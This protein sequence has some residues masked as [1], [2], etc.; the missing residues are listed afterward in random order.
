MRT[1]E[2]P[3]PTTRGAL[4]QTLLA[5]GYTPSY[6]KNEFGF[7]FVEYSH[8]ESGACVSLRAVPADEALTA[9]DLLS[10]EH[11]VEWWGVS[12]LRTFY[13]LLQEATPAEAQVA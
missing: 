10:A 12:N 2:M 1:F 13:R 7:P 3:F 9:S 4:E 6:G 8:K 11:S 5:L